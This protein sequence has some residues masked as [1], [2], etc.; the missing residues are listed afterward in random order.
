LEKI[1]AAH[2]IG[3][4]D[5]LRRR[6]IAPRD[7]D[8]GLALFNA[9]ADNLSFRLALGSYLGAFSPRYLDDRRRAAVSG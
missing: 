1:G 6:P 3:L 2:A 9:V 7:L 5:A 8:D 4:E